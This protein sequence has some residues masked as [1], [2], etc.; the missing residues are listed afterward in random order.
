MFFPRFFFVTTNSYGATHF[1][2][3]LPLDRPYLLVDVHVQGM[4]SGAV[5]WNVLEEQLTH[6]RTSAD[7]IRKNI[8]DF[9]LSQQAIMRG[10]KQGTQKSE[11]GEEVGTRPISSSME[12]AVWM[13]TTSA[14]EDTKSKD[15]ELGAA[16][17]QRASVGVMSGARDCYHSWVV[18]TKRARENNQLHWETVD[19]LRAVLDLSTHLHHYPVPLATDLARYVVA[20]DDL[21]IPRHHITNV[22]TTWPGT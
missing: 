1:F 4:L 15:R 17:G 7:K 10:G 12:S 5:S 9:A 11:Y 13:S 3:L 2:W 18:N 6:S 22:Q 8:F 20:K 21:Y 14:S 16:Q 19:T